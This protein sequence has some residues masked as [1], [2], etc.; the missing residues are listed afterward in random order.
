[1]GAH[2][3][4]DRLDQIAI[5]LAN[6]LMPTP[7]DPDRALKAYTLGLASAVVKT[8]AESLR[9]H[10]TRVKAGLRPYRAFAPRGLLLS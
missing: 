10:A 5:D 4:A 6:A 1:M 2:E 9:S 7:D 3:L 8:Q